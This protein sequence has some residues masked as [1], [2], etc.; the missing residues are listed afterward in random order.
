MQY[1]LLIVV[2]SGRPES[3]TID[4][5]EWCAEITAWYHKWGTL[6]MVAGGH[7][8]QGPESART[9]RAAQVTDGPFIEGQA[10]ISGYTIFE[11][12]SITS[13][14]EVAKTWPGV[15]RGWISIEIRPLAEP[16]IR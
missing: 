9:L 12:T 11:T 4:Y 10:F 5:H 14:V 16:G 3:G 1:M 2:M 15:D 6:G 8:L 7:E 13:A